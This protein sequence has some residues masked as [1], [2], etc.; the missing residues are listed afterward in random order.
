MRDHRS[1]GAPKTIL[2]A[3]SISIRLPARNPAKSGYEPAETITTRSEHVAWVRIATPWSMLLRFSADNLRVIDGSLYAD[4]DQRKHQSADHGYGGE[5]CRVDCREVT[6]CSL[7]QWQEQSET[8]AFHRTGH[9]LISRGPARCRR[10]TRRC[11]K[12][13]SKRL[14]AS[15]LDCPG[16]DDGPGL[17]LWI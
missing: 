6:Q 7:P 2:S 5:S 3:N 13:G 15:S 14:R 1:A 11:Q 8:P 12:N 9:R 17:L 16:S 10:S 4:R